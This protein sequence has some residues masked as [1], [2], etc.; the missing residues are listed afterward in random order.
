[1]IRFCRA[2]VDVF[3][4]CLILFY[5]CRPLSLLVK[6]VE[7]ERLGRSIAGTLGPSSYANVAFWLGFVASNFSLPYLPLMSGSFGRPDMPK[8]RTFLHSKQ[9]VD[10]FGIF[11][12]RAQHLRHEI[13][14]INGR[15]KY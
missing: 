13:R 11:T 4:A 2:L 3:V 1:M 9:P 14:G 10:R 7:N 15:L 8:L 12:Q 5:E 6:H